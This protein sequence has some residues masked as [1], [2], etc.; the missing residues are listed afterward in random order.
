MYLREFDKD[1]QKK[2]LDLAYTLLVADGNEISRIEQKAIEAYQFE[3]SV[4]TLQAKKI[5]YEQIA[6]E[7]LYLS[8]SEK[9]KL[10]FELLALALV[11]KEYS[12][13]EQKLIKYLSEKWNISSDEICEMKSVIEQQMNLYERINHLLYA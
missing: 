5:D 4:D 7:L 11:D 6:N 1:V 12:S 3:L 2:Y 10:F 9:R 8:I 13:G